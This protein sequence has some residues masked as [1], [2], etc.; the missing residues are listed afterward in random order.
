MT[1]SI[2]FFRHGEAFQIGENNIRT[3]DERPLTPKGRSV[4]EEVCLALAKMDIKP[5]MIW[6]SP[7]VRAVETADIISQDTDC[8]ILFEKSGLAWPDQEED[9]FSNRA[10]SR[11]STCSLSATSP[12]LAIGFAALP[13]ESTMEISPFQKAVSHVSIS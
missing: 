6:H 1:R 4:T 3:D 5:D 2:F 13:P 10:P 8:S 11:I 7:L 12:I 9:L